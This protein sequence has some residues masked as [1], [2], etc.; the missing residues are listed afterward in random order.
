M[1]T[2]DGKI[3]V[4]RREKK[5]FGR[6]KNNCKEKQSHYWNWPKKSSFLGVHY[7]NK[8]TSCGELGT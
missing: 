2:R 7:N 5:M 4:V 1:A 3:R 6:R 8:P